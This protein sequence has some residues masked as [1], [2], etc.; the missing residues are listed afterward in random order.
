MTPARYSFKFRIPMPSLATRVSVVV[1]WFQ[2]WFMLSGS[3]T[4]VGS[5]F[6]QIGSGGESMKVVTET[7]A[8]LLLHRCLS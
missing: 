8:A 2:G 1:A 6:D 5:F 3:R 4:A 7:S